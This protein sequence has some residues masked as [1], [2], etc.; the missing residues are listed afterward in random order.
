MAQSPGTEPST[1]GLLRLLLFATIAL[2]LLIGGGAAYLSYRDSD[3]Q[4]IISASEAVAVAAANTAKVLDTH[5]LVA[6]RIGDLLGMMR[7]D[8]IRAAEKSLHDRMAQQIATMPEVAAAWVID[9][10]G[11]E[12]VS[13]RVYPVN[14]GLDQSGRDDYRALRSSNTQTFISMLRARRLDDGEFEPYFTVSLRRAAPDGR[15]NGVIVVA[16]ASSYFASFYDSLLGS[17]RYAAALLK[18]D[19]V[20]LARYPTPDFTVGPPLPD[21]LLVKAIAEEPTTGIVESGTPFDGAGRIVAV[22]RVGNYPVY[23]TV[24]RRKASVLGDWLE[25]VA[26]YAGIGAPAAIALI[27]LS[28][29]ALRRARREELA[30]VRAG[31]AFAGRAALEVRLHRAQRLEAM[32]LLATGVATDFTKAASEIRHNIECA[33]ASIGDPAA[34]PRPLLAAAQDGCLR[35][36]NLAQRLLSL[37]QSEPLQPQFTDLNEVLDDLLELTWP[38]GK[39]IVDE[40][41]LQEDLWP[42]Q[43]NPD[44]LA[45]ALL[46]FAFHGR[47]TTND[48][49]GLIIEASNRSFDP[50]GFDGAP[51]GDYVELIIEGAADDAQDISDLVRLGGFADRASGYGTIEGVPGRHATMRLH[52]PRYRRE[53]TE[54][55]SAAVAAPDGGRIGLVAHP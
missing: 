16:V 31:K 28:V 42:V 14:P 4:A 26:G 13:A 20:T 44:Q 6:A 10:A 7:D 34:Q 21:P 37:T 11:R 53:K 41:R 38:S 39:P 18:S 2:P 43:T 23:A 5:L 50:A 48:E 22:K 54:A 1:L 9:A 19:G 33:A 29:L 15:F 12:L 25:T 51:P 8:Q 46:N 36:A 17:G 40:V 35:A 49:G 47:S 30:V 55:A 52:L 27:A 45:T 24:E 3:R 32:G